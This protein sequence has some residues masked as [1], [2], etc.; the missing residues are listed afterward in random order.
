MAIGLGEL[1]VC[2]VIHRDY[3]SMN[4]FL[5]D[6]LLKIGDLGVSK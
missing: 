1:H 6:N 5:N 4:I 2:N 3:K